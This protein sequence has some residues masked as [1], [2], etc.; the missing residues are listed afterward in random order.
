MSEFKR[1]SGPVL[2]LGSSGLDIVGR[3]SHALQAGTSNPARLRMSNG[4]VGRNIAEAL[5]RLGM[6]AA[7]ITVVGE[8]G[9]GQR[10]LEE[11]AAA[12]VDTSPALCLP[13]A[14]TGAYLA[15]LD[16][17]GNLQF[18]LDDMHAMQHLLPSHLH[19][20]RK[21][22]KQASAIVIDAN[23]APR[24]MNTVMS[25]ARQYQVPV[26]ADP[27]SASLAPRL[28]PHLNQLWL[29][30]PNEAEAETLCPHPVP[31]AD[32]DRVID[33]ARHLVSEGVQI[34]I[35]TMAEFGVGYASTYSSG[36]VPA[37]K[38]EVLDPTGAHDALTATVL[39]ALLND[40][41]LDEAVRLGVSAAALTLRL[42]GTVA[43]DL[44]L[45]LLYDQLR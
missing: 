24:T 13:E 36:H 33:A 3:A 11:T 37:V 45:E 4:G 40:I 30:T 17:E 9:P 38:T 39:F 15:V 23:L 10:L 7:L 1:R 44:S 20:R 25:L 32:R 31:H 22:F 27:T 5:S 29:V 12:G 21:W 41:P 42:H 8:D 18:G 35:I 19:Q 6:R 28:K 34:A 43:P 26:V 16:A 2:V 14:R